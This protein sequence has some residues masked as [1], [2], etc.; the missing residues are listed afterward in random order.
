MN[1]RTSF[2]ILRAAFGEDQLAN[3]GSWGAFD[4]DL[5][6]RFTSDEVIGHKRHLVPKPAGIV[7]KS[8]LSGVPSVPGMARQVPRNHAENR[9]FGRLPLSRFTR[10]RSLVRSQPR[11]F[12]NR[13]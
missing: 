8:P 9:P 5:D 3:S 1:S 10:G 4:C 7:R 12:R 2:L 11:P 13:R 6:R